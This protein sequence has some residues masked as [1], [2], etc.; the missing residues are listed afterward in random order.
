MTDTPEQEIID[1]KNKKINTIKRNKKSGSKFEAD[2]REGL[3]SNG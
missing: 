2:V 3:R 1:K